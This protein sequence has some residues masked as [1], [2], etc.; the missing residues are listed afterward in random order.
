MKCILSYEIR[1]KHVPWLRELRN[2]KIILICDDSGT[3]RQRVDGTSR[4]RWDELKVFA[5][6]VVEFVTLFN[7]HGIDIRFLNRTCSRTITDSSQLE[8]LF[9]AP[10]LGYTPL[11]SVLRNVLRSRDPQREDEKFLIFIATDGMPTDDYGDDDLENFQNVMDVERDA[12]NTHVMFLICTDDEEVVRYFRSWD[13]RMKNVDVTDDYKTQKA[14][15]QKKGVEKR[16]F[17]NA[18]YVV[19][20]LV[21][22]INREVNFWDADPEEIVDLD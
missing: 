5:Q 9:E 10:P 17:T 4:T 11:A 20:I 8:K 2:Y 12:S 13:N 21:G 19:K 14:L 3:M 18:D 7:P 15:V 16:P 22:A 1:R 6:Y